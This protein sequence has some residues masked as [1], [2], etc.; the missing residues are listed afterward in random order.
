MSWA[1]AG[2]DYY[3]VGPGSDWSLGD[4]CCREGAAVVVATGSD[5]PA[6]IERAWL[7]AVDG[8]AWPFAASDALACRLASCQYAFEGASQGSPAGTP[9]RTYF[10]CF[11][12]MKILVES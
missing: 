10:E 1:G 8:L 7:A 11:L 9:G 3:S 4:Y 5:V 2:L 12:K 6:S